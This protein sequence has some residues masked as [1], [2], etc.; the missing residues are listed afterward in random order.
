M[1]ERGASGEENHLETQ[2]VSIGKSY[3]IFN[4]LR[5]IRVISGFANLCRRAKKGGEVSAI[6]LNCEPGHGEM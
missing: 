2:K 1:L 6:T 4:L 5:L 3:D